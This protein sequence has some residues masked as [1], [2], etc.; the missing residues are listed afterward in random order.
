MDDVARDQHEHGD[1]V[2]QNV[3][4]MLVR[5]SMNGVFK[6]ED[7]LLKNWYDYIMWTTST[8]GFRNR[9]LLASR[10]VPALI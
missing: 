2:E 6:H 10:L 4:S 7:K 8:A 3:H 1:E 5:I 9:K